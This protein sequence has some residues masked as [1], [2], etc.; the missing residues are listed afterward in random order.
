LITTTAVGVRLLLSPELGDRTNYMTFFAAVAISAALGGWGPGLVSALLCAVVAFDILIPLGYRPFRI[1]ENEVG[2][3]L[4][5][6]VSAILILLAELH[7]RAK[8]RAERELAGRYQAEAHEAYQRQRFETILCS[9]GDGVIATDPEGRITFLNHAA[10][11]LTGWSQADALGR[12][13][14]EVVVILNEETNAPVEN[15]AVRAMREA[16]STGLASQ[17]VLRTRTGERIPIADSGAPIH[18]A[19]GEIT[20]AVCA[21]HSIAEMR[22]REA[23][24][25][26]LKRLIDLSEDAIIVTDQDRRI[27]SWNLGAKEM[28]GWESEEARGQLIHVLL[29]TRRA[30]EENREQALRQDGYWEGEMTKFRK[31]GRAVQCEVRAVQALDAQGKVECMLTVDRDVTERRRMEER[32][33]ERAKLE[34][35]GVLAG[36]VAHDFNNLLTG[37]LGNAS[38]LMDDAPPDSRAWSFAKAICESGDR[39]AKL[40]QQM[41]AY[42]GRGRFVVQPLN[43]S[44]VVSRNADLLR[45]SVPKNVKLAFHLADD[46]PS[47]DADAM[48]MQQLLVNLVINGA[49]AIGS[50]GGQVTVT[51]SSQ[52]V[53]EPYRR[54][55]L[56]N[57][58]VQ[59]GTYACL[60][61]SDTGSGMDDETLSRIFDPFFTTKFVGRGLGLAAVQGIIRGHK[62]VIEV[63]SRV[64]EGTRFRIL[65]PA[66]AAA[67]EESIAPK[68]Q[69]ADARSGT[70]L[71]I[72]DEEIVR[73]T[74]NAALR[75]QGYDVITA[76]D[77]TKGLEE[78]RAHRTAIRLVLLDLT[79]P[80][81][82]SEETMR[83]IRKIAPDVPVL[84]SSGYSE[85]EALRRLEKHS[86]AGFLQKP[87][88]GRQLAMRVRAAIGH[89]ASSDI[90]K[91]A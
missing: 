2:F 25:G 70:I 57:E 66:N 12:P 62:G 49:E 61:V 80:G 41:L 21:F 39:A 76:S 44:E 29:R 13:V 84:L 60:E 11:D 35:L 75:W 9:I 91:A 10:S 32:L 1:I 65:F 54:T 59:L 34:S 63:S 19:S 89:A 78:L 52:I 40:A 20:G 3:T 58:H 4:Y 14:E 67:L 8:S 74:A 68:L 88:T 64:A 30:D 24:L 83:E 53:D 38:L 26:R 50:R 18:S 23:E 72:D 77:G 69:A 17:S 15:P 45:S 48:Q 46:L 79:M 28:Y 42:S 90:P 47:I 86:L 16:H 22:A 87:Y 82:S 7:R 5:L 71:V 55:L 6:F 43:L 56:L 31:D 37:I 81:M 36:G 51:T 85:A 73:S 33:R 27:L